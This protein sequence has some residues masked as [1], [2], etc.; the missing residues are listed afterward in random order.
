MLRDPG[1]VLK[2]LMRLPAET[3]WIEFKEAKNNFDSDD[4]GKYFSALSNEANLKGQETGWLVFGVTDRVPRK[5]VGSNYRIQKPGLEKLLLKNL[6]D[7]LSSDQ[8]KNFVTNLLQEMR[9]EKVI[10][11]VE[12]K[13]GKGSKWVLYK[14]V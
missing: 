4:L 7:A 6:S 1:I 12:G 10:R 9:R 3:E 2:E 8:K 14:Q 11:P 5:I 13:R